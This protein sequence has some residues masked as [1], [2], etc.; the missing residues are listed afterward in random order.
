MGQILRPIAEKASR[1][2]GL[3]FD[4]F[5][6]RAFEEQ[7]VQWLNETEG[8]L[9]E[10]DGYDCRECRNKG[11][12]VRLEENYGRLQQISRDCKCREIRNSIARMKK[13]GLKDII[14]DY[15]F[16]KYT[17]E[18]PWQQAIKAAAEDY[19]KAP[20]GWF[21]IGG[22]S[23]AGKTHLC[24]AICRKQLLEG[25]SVQYMMWRDDIVRIKSAAADREDPSAHMQKFK[26]ADVLYIDDLFKTGRAPDGSLP[27][28]TSAD[29]NYAFEILNYRYNNHLPTIVSSEFV[30][31]EL[32]EIDEAIGGRICERAKA[33]SIAK[34]RKKNWRT[35][36]AVTL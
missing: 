7:S 19:A 2:T 12:I 24:T 28:P 1:N 17:A 22:Q 30:L 23:G 15:T 5:D 10:L 18:E 36:N 16:D 8:K 14:R 34:D 11:Y 26:T 33:F 21:F 13:S 20:E 4:N 29:I 35:R 31:E 25:K 9:H 6:R 27:R 32:L 3:S